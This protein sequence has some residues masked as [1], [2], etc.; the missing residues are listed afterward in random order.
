MALV[1]YSGHLMAKKKQELQE[2]AEKL[3]ISTAGTKEEIHARIKSHL[4]AHDLSEDPVY[5]GLYP[6]KR[7]LARK[8]TAS[9]MFVHAPSVLSFQ[10]DAFFPQNQG[11]S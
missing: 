2:I 4:D 8:E 11:P 5:A 6:A 3:S 1:Q 9:T 7:K 10:P